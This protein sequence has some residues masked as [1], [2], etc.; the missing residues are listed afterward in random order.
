[1]YPVKQKPCHCCGAMP[2]PSIKPQWCYVT[3][4]K[5]LY[6]VGKWSSRRNRQIELLAN[7]VP[8]RRG[9]WVPVR[10]AHFED[11]YT[12]TRVLTGGELLAYS[13]EKPDVD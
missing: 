1:M 3:P 6:K 10:V 7:D 5:K 2:L 9:E 11:W 4:G 12:N 8:A 13:V